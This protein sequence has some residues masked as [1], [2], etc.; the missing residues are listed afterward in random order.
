MS[1]YLFHKTKVLYNDLKKGTINKF[2]IKSMIIGEK[3]LTTSPFGGN[4]EISLTPG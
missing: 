4:R 2:G 3:T 1:H